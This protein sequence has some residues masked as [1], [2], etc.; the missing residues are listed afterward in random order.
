MFPW[1]AKT[2][3]NNEESGH[4]STRIHASITHIHASI[5]HIHS[6][7]STHTSTP[8][9]QPHT[10]TPSHRDPR[11]PTTILSPAIRHNQNIGDS[12]LTKDPQSIRF[13]L[14]NPNGL[15]Y[16][17]SCFEYQLCLEQMKSISADVIMLPKTHLLWK[18]YQVF[19]QTT[20]HRRNIF[21]HSC[22]NTSSSKGHYNSPYQPGGTCSIITDSIVGHYHSSYNDPS[23]G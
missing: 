23:L 19:K 12:V 14:Q 1:T 5:T 2:R 6:P 17:E 22:Q 11:S 15:S 20:D 8:S 9:H 13:V 4:S 3:M 18:D 7:Q 10:S 16:H 21:D